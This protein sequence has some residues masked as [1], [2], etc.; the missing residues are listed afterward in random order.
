[1]TREY[2]VTIQTQK[3]APQ[4]ADNVLK[5]FRCSISEPSVWLTPGITTER[6]LTFQDKKGNT[7]NSS[8]FKHQAYFQGNQTSRSETAEIEELI[9][10]IITEHYHIIRADI[11][12]KVS[13]IGNP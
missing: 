5:E 7:L 8:L 13:E 1:M 6:G 12:V 2:T 3:N 11:K 4:I 10:T 9:Y